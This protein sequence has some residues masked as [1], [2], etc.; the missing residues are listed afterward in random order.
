MLILLYYLILNLP[1]ISE[2]WLLVFWLLFYTGKTI[3]TVTN[4]NLWCLF[5]LIFIFYCMLWTYF[6]VMGR[7][8]KR[9]CI[10]WISPIWSCNKT[11]LKVHHCSRILRQWKWGGVVMSRSPQEA[12]LERVGAALIQ[13]PWKEK[14][15]GRS[16]CG[17]KLHVDVQ[18]SVWGVLD[19]ECFIGAIL[20]WPEMTLPLCI[21]V[22]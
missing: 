17:Q 11:L 16:G 12:D 22:V 18:L 15:E 5:S 20:C 8:Y 1:C 13:Y 6:N 9:K 10:C 3:C 21:H 19:L 14:E 4:C 2:L 7:G